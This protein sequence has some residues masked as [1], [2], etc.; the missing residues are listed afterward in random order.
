MIPTKSKTSRGPWKKNVFQSSPSKF[1]EDPK[2][3][4][5]RIAANS[6]SNAT[7][8][9]SISSFGSQ[10]S[11]LSNGER[12]RVRLPYPKISSCSTSL[13][14][15]TSLLIDDEGGDRSRLPPILLTPVAAAKKVNVSPRE[16]E[17]SEKLR[18]ELHRSR[19]DNEASERR[20]SRLVRKIEELE[21]SKSEA[22]GIQTELEDMDK[23]LH[24]AIVENKQLK[25]KLGIEGPSSPRGDGLEK[26]EKD[27]FVGRIKGK[28]RK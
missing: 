6:L 13:G 11:T 23:R 1:P 18:L 17:N 20:I 27:A 16:K 26:Q 4:E 9:S 3:I 8:G 21:L 22:K 19:L 14:S 25:R 12:D 10:T 7:S 5:P 15:R 28:E 2:V 24:S